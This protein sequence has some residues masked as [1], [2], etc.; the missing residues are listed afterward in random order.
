MTAAARGI[1]HVDLDEHRRRAEPGELGG[2][3]RTPVG[4]APG[5]HE[6][7]GTVGHDLSGD[8][9]TET[10]RAAA[11]D[12]DLARELARTVC[13]IPILCCCFPLTIAALAACTSGRSLTSG[14]P[15]SQ[16]A[17]PP[18]HE[19]ASVCR[20][21]TVV[22]SLCRAR[23]ERAL[24]L[25]HRCDTLAVAA[26]RRGVGGEVDV[27]QLAVA[28][29]L[30]QVVE[31]HAA[32]VDLQ[33][34]DDREAAV[35]AD[36]H[37]QLVAGEHRAVQVAVHHHVRAVADERDDLVVGAGHLGAP[38]TGDLVAHAREPVLAVEVADLLGTPAVDQL[39]GQTAGRGEHVVASAAAL[40]RRRRSPARTSDVRWRRR[41]TGRR[42]RSM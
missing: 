3:R 35:V 42:G 27:D 29:V 13:H 21:M 31:R 30:D 1:G 19:Y 16:N 6:A 8:R 25:V 23:F 32:L 36:D 40:D 39:A 34:V 18:V 33:P 2:E 24:Q 15:T 9:L 5:E 22:R 4:A 37:D 41:R 28:S 11:D 38:R 17:P 14:T 7:G 10:L 12:D 20:A 26:H